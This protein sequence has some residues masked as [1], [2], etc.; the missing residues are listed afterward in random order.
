MTSY[1]D[2]EDTKPWTKIL[3][4]DGEKALK[5]SIMTEM[6]KMFPGVPNP[7]FFKSHLWSKGTT[8]WTPG[9]YDPVEMGEKIMNPLPNFWPNLYVC[10]ESFSQ[11]QAWVE[12]A[13]ENADALIN[14]FF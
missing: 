3:K 11:R 2:A 12:G 10:G 9:L 1:T 7:L 13:L 14:K 8:Y 5:K 6:T 4:T